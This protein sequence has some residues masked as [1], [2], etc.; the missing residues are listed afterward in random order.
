MNLLL[1]LSVKIVTGMA[2]RFDYSNLLQEAV[3]TSSP[4]RPVILIGDLAAVYY[5]REQ[6]KMNQHGMVLYS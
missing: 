6:G 3:G 1:K 2:E 4:P 5:A